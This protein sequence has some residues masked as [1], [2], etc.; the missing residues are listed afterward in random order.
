MRIALVLERLDP[1]RGGLE[2]WTW[3]FANRLIQ[4]RHEVHVAAT[5]FTPQIRNTS[6]VAHRLEGVRSRL[7]FAQAAEAK[8]RPL[9]FDVI[10]DMGSGWY[11]DVFQP[12]GGSWFSVAQRKLLLHS[13]WVRPLKRMAD[14]LLPRQREFRALAARQ[15]ADRGQI[16][17]AL[18]GSVS[19][20]FQLLHAVTPDRIRVVYN[21]VDTDRFSPRHRADYRRPIRAK[22]GID[23]KTVLALIVAHNFRLKGVPALLSAMGRLAAA[24][25]PIHLVVV[26][27]KRLGGWRRAA[28]RA[29][30]ATNVTFTGP[31]SDTIP[32]YAAADFYVHPTWYDACSLVLLEAAASGLPIITTTRFNGAVEL[33]GDHLKRLLLS[34]PNDASRLAERMRALLDGSLRRRIG[35][36]LR[37][38]A[39]NYTLDRNVEEML[40]VYREVVDS[41]RGRRPR[42]TIPQAAS[43]W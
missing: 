29:G 35:D 27:G 18:S 19:D 37:Q 30:A 2:Q 12:H 42:R 14:R 43:P 28:A 41:R 15:Y 3:R 4:R 10:H 1:Q 22:L 16:L 8:L 34:D 21:G 39:L 33:F 7:G 40:E 5:C 26:G 25:L 9:S 32:Y 31:V 24:G 36:A 23:D 38:T 11:C 17:V 20:D 13:P 6:I